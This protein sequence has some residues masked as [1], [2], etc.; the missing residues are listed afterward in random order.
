MP[1]HSCVSPRSASC[2]ENFVIN[3]QL[4]GPTLR[5]SIEKP[6]NRLARD[7]V[8]WPGYA[9]VSPFYDRWNRAGRAE[10]KAAMRMA[11]MMPTTL[12]GA[13]A[14]IAH[15]QREAM[16]S[17]DDAEDWLAPALKTVAVALA[18]MEAA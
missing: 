15:I 10:R 1:W 5:L 14:L 8:D 3:N 9:I 6:Q 18:R 2:S 11:R 7:E 13:A 17:F 12:A 4:S 16:A